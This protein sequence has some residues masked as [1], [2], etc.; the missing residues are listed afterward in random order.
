M[1]RGIHPGFHSFIL[2]RLSDLRLLMN[3]FS[4][5]LRYG[6]IAAALFGVVA[7]VLVSRSQAERQMPPPGDP[8]GRRHRYS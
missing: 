1:D 3:F 5:L 4:K 7:I 8:P 6:S 2:C